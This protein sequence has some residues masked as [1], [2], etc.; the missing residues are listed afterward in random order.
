MLPPNG[1]TKELNVEA[2]QATIQA[3]PPAH[4]YGY[5][6]PGAAF[7]VF[8]MASVADD[9][10]AWG[11]SW[12]MRDKKLRSFWPTE[13][14]LAGAIYS[15]M[16]R[17]ASLDIEFDGPPRTVQAVQDMWNGVEYGKGPL[18]MLQK[19]CIDFLS[20]DNGCFFE[21]MRESNGDESVLMGKKP[22]PPVISLAH[23]DAGQCIRTGNPYF[24]VIFQDPDN[25][26]YHELAWYQV[27]T[28]EEMP[29]P[30]KRMRNM[31]YSACTRILRA[32]Q[33]LRDI[34]IYQR[35]KIGGRS[36]TSVHLVSG[37][38][39]A[40]ID[41]GMKLGHEK[42][43]NQGFVR[44]MMPVILA[45]LDP[46]A[47]PAHVEI[48]LKSLP[49]GFDQDI[50]MRWYIAQLALSFGADYQDFAPLPGSGLGTSEQS[51]T[52]DRKSSGKGK[53][54][55]V[56]KMTWMLNFYGLLPKNVTAKYQEKDSLAER[57][58][59]TVKKMRADTHKVQLDGGMITTAVA[60]QM[61]QDEGDLKPEYLDLMD[62]SDVTEDITQ[63]A[64]EPYQTPENVM[65]LPGT[66]VAPIAPVTTPP[67]FGKG[68]DMF[69]AMRSWFGTV[70][71]W[72]RKDAEQSEALRVMR[73]AVKALESAPAPRAPVVNVAPAQITVNV[74]EQKQAA[75]VDFRP[76]ADAI[77]AMPA[78][79]VTVEVPQ[80]DEEIEITARDADG[81]AK[82]IHKKRIKD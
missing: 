38:A 5:G 12:R 57:D 47:S 39:Q 40:R 25:G 61:M 21:I 65:P 1:E 72:N 80:H 37:V 55:W 7:L 28:L 41:D 24:P 8:D 63:E 70:I 67:A 68:L 19:G 54:L 49:D 9:I 53:A 43:D 22:P 6:Q 3:V 15:I 69:D 82:K 44:Y 51:K 73:K 59:W 31:Q 2:L 27:I 16:A 11:T 66:M 60:R 50:A 58:E 52:L 56:K 29:S 76:L 20:Q 45:S 32:A 33:V 75:P 4:S 17:N 62:E 18:V 74:P 35:E 77:K 34:S 14:V 36:P 64:D 81:R 42:A 30:V 23:L 79:R 46:N 10:P 13:N 78:P 48:P 71:S 26:S